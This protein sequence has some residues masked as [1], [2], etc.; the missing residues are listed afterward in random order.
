MTM[1]YLLTVFSVF[2]IL[3]LSAQKGSISGKLL[4][5]N[6]NEGIFNAKISIKSIAKGVISDQE[7][8][9][10]FNDLAPGVYTIEIKATTYNN[11]I[12]TDIAVVSG[13]DYYS[14]IDKTLKRF[15]KG[16]SFNSDYTDLIPPSETY[17][18]WK[19]DSWKVD[20]ILK[21]EY[22]K[23][24]CKENAKTLIASS[25]WSVLPDVNITNKSDFENYRSILRN[26][27]INPI[28]DPIFPIE[29][30]PI[31]SK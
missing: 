12:I 21:S 29:P 4:D 7:G 15:V 30:N 2:F 26:L 19:N 5:A 28:E 16:E 1:K 27:I 23:N 18:I 22:L 14:K 3:L 17:I 25:D 11:K 24:Q 10:S 13:K 20:E 31:W 8:K 9:F 6:N